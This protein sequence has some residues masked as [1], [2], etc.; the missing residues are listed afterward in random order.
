MLVRTTKLSTHR[1]GR[2]SSRGSTS[3]IDTSRLPLPCGN[4]GCHRVG[5]VR[6]PASRVPT[7]D[8][9]A[10]GEERVLDGKENLG[11]RVD[12]RE[13]VDERGHHA[14]GGGGTSS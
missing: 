8:L 9:D 7:A 5:S 4:P 12:V 13:Q 10:V 1:P 11:T 6:K 14:G 3:N 2:Q